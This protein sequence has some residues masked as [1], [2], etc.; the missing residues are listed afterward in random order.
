MHV[1]NTHFLDQAYSL[2]DETGP[3]FESKEVQHENFYFI[4][5]YLLKKIQ[6]FFME[7]RLLNFRKSSVFDIPIAHVILTVF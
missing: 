5:A 4:L 2:T 6:A 1:V 3:D 7:F